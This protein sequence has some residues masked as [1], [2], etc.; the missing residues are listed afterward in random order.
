MERSGSFFDNSMHQQDGLARRSTGHGVPHGTSVPHPTSHNP[1]CA[2]VKIR[3]R[4]TSAQLP[5]DQQ[6]ASIPQGWRDPPTRA[7]RL[8]SRGPLSLG[9]SPGRLDP[10]LQ[11]PSHEALGCLFRISSASTP[12]LFQEGTWGRAASARQQSGNARLGAEHY[13]DRSRPD[14]T[15]LPHSPG[16]PRPSDHHR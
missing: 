5:V 15:I 8:R 10:T 1:T 13:R 2:L 16:R 9:P 11:L 14:E 3:R 7:S 4:G 6:D 12:S